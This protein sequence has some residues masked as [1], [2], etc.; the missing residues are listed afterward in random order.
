ME[1]QLRERVGRNM[2]G[3]GLL[4]VTMQDGRTDGEVKGHQ[5]PGLRVALE[6][7]LRQGVCV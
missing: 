1:E 7:L 2:C 6:T 4:G 3:A 5:H